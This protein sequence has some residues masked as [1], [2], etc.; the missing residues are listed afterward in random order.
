MD[1]SV[2]KTEDGLTR[3]EWRWFETVAPVSDPLSAVPTVRTFTYRLSD[4]TG[5]DGEKIAHFMYEK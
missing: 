1:G 5:P 4:E 3:V 2:Q